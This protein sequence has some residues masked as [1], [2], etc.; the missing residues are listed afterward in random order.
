[1]PGLALPSLE[2]PPSAGGWARGDRQP[3]PSLGLRRRARM[4][5][6]GQ[7]GLRRKRERFRGLQAAAAVGRI[8]AE[9]KGEELRQISE[10]KARVVGPGGVQTIREMGEESGRRLQ[11][12]HQGK[13]EGSWA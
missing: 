13:G 12:H 5:G 8:E 1:M 7:A 3:T 4:G 6:A 11:Q 9:D 10:G 2:P